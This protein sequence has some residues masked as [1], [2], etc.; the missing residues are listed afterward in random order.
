MHVTYM[1][2]NHVTF[3][4]PNAVEQCYACVGV[5]TSV[6]HYTIITEAYL[7]HLVYQ[8]TLNIALVITYL[9][10]WK[11]IAQLWQITLKRVFTI[12]ARLANSKK[13]EVRAVY[14]QYFPHHFNFC[15]AF[16]FDDLLSLFVNKW[17]TLTTKLKIKD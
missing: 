17:L 13:V 1:H 5:G 9:H 2:F 14:Y 6:E 4:R 15:S 10:I 3:K 8:F 12:N 11:H 16:L 7:L